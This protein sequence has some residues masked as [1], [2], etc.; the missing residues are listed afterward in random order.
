MQVRCISTKGWLRYLMVNR[1]CSTAASERFNEFP[2]FSSFPV[3]IQCRIFKEAFPDPE[4]VYWDF[5]VTAH[6]GQDNSHAE[7]FRNYEKIEINFPTPVAFHSCNQSDCSRYLRKTVDTLLV[8]FINLVSLNREG[9]SM[10]LNNITYLALDLDFDPPSYMRVYAKLYIS[11]SI[12][13]PA[14]STL[15]FVFDYG[16]DRADWY[17]TE[18]RQLVDISEG[19][20]DLDWEF[21]R[22]K[23]SLKKRFRNP[24]YP[25]HIAYIHTALEDLKYIDRESKHLSK[26]FHRFINT[27]ENDMWDKPGEETLK[28]WENIRSTPVLM[29]R[30]LDHFQASPCSCK[31]EYP[32]LY[33]R[34]NEIY[35]GIR[36][37]GTPMHMYTGLRQIF[38][39]EPW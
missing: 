31:S 18:Y 32:E 3:E 2:L 15:Y 39:G 7:V 5:D 6:R 38:D 27:T 37:D 13:C 29:L 34:H 20:V 26:S 36:K 22:L 25:N 14:L 12:H 33:S 24:P 16:P 1:A 8:S 9:G 21:P 19:C 11:I 17:A 10:P 23:Q 35:L 28:Y 4:I 30:C